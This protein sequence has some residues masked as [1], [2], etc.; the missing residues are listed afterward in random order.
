[1]SITGS[2]ANALSGLN[3]TSRRAEI[4][5]ANIANANTPGYGVRKLDVSA[6]TVAGR[7]SGVRIDGVSRLVDNGIVQDRRLADASLGD[8]T[9]RS[10]FFARVEKSIGIPGTAGSL[11]G[12]VADLEASLIS[13]ASRPDSEPRLH[14]VLNEARGITKHL[15]T[16]SDDVQTIRE[17]ADQDIASN[18]KKLNDG[19]QQVREINIAIA[20]TQARG[21]DGASLEDQR[22][23]II[24]GIASI[25]PIR[26]VPR[27][28]G[29]VALFTPGGAVLV[30]SKASVFEFQATGVITPSMTPSGLLS[31]LT[32]NGN[33][34]D[35]S[36]SNSILKGGSLIANFA[37]RDEL[38][39]E[40]QSQLD[41]VARNLIERFQSPTVDPTL[42]PL[43]AG[44]FTDNGAP[45]DPA[46]EL[47]LSARLQINP[48]TDPQNGGEIRRL[49]DGL[50]A[51]I[52]GNV[53]YSTQLQRLTSALQT[54][55]PVT[56][57]NFS[58]AER[59]MSTLI[60]DLLSEYGTARQ[61]AEADVAY[62]N[63]QHQTFKNL[64]LQS[65]VDTDREMQ[66]L[67]LVEQ[68]YAANARVLQT[69]DELIQTLIGL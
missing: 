45:L 50:G 8:S 19:L 52:P 66:E 41:A 67:L 33:P 15:K 2:I 18:V 21:L 57:G 48:S 28:N 64:E 49:R 40:A 63:V 46:A 3:A 7:G 51:T 32:L 17:E 34:V 13:A 61:A 65:G 36:S 29:T 44:L 37:V 27:D 68:A 5:S 26:Q 12:R 53:G 35:T 20:A 9:T 16:A 4:V 56:S 39:V 69:V 60:S 54:Q 22:Q 10:A 1:M 14:D 55:Q 11:S 58:A 6:A 43:D 38:A 25:V 47:G 59:G 24:D 30:D 23:Q 42:G 62:S 31:G